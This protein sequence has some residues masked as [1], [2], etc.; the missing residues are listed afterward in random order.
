MCFLAVLCQLP[1]VCIKSAPRTHGHSL[2]QI[3]IH[4]GIHFSTIPPRTPFLCDSI[5]MAAVVITAV[6]L[7]CSTLKVAFVYTSL[8]S[9][10]FLCHWQPFCL[11]YLEFGEFPGT[12]VA[13]VL[14]SLLPLFNSFCQLS[15]HC[16]LQK[17]ICC[18]QQRVHI[19]SAWRC[20][21]GCC[22]CLLLVYVSSCS[23]AS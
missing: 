13:A 21:P 19:W 12:C 15:Y 3:Y 17:F 22:P 6:L 1:S 23:A 18:R 10:A 16:W 11:S 5:A 8:S 2:F 4:A 14:G 9:A 7:L 20:C